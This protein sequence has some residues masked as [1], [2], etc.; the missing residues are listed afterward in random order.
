MT[1]NIIYLF[2]MGVCL[3]SGPCLVSCG[4]VLVSYVT[5]CQ[6]KPAASFLIYLFFSLGRIVVYLIFIVILFFLGKPIFEKFTQATARYFSLGGGLLIIFLGTMIIL[7]KKRANLFCTFKHNTMLQ[8]DSI[9]AIFLGVILGFLPCASLIA[10]FSY[11]LLLAQSWIQAVVY[12]FSFSL[13]TFFSVL[14]VIMIGAG[15]FNQVL[16]RKTELYGRITGIMCGLIIIGIGITFIVN[17]F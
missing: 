13:G 6:R 3:G 17:A 16:A 10:V 7:D 11:I 9:Q 12:C 2:I 14:L 4:P 15:F 5:G 1:K 8:T